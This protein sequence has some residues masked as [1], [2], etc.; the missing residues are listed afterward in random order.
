MSIIQLFRHILRFPCKLGMIR[1]DFTTESLDCLFISHYRKSAGRFGSALTFFRSVGTTKYFTCSFVISI[2]LGS[3]VHLICPGKSEVKSSQHLLLVIQFVSSL[4]PVL[5]GPSK[6]NRCQK[7][8]NFWYN[9]KIFRLH[10][11]FRPRIYVAFWKAIH[12]RYEL[13]NF[14][15]YICKASEKWIC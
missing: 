9:N 10:S 4:L 11:S 15:R 3:N 7:K 2:Q 5:A 12:F 8:H 1:I 13:L 6:K 14:D